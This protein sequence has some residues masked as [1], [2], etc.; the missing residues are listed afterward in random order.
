MTIRSLSLLAAL[1]VAAALPAAATQVGPGTVRA[2]VP[3]RVLSYASYDPE[4]CA[5][6]ALPVLRVVRPP[7][8]GTLVLGKERRDAG[9][10]VICPV[11]TLT[12]TTA[13]YKSAPGF[14]GRDEMEVEASMDLYTYRAGTTVDRILIILDVK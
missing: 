8:H 7:A 2:G 3:T 11:K 1:S 5:T 6:A 13:V 14:K 4:T 10:N 9:K 12:A